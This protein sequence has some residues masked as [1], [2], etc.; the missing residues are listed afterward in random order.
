MR[1]CGKRPLP[2]PPLA[3][4]S[5]TLSRKRERV[6]FAPPFYTISPRARSAGSRIAAILSGIGHGAA[7]E[8]RR[9]G[10]EIIG[11]GGGHGGGGLRPDAAVDLDFDVASA[12]HLAHGADLV[13]RTGD[14]AL[15]AEAGID[16]HHQHEVDEVE[17]MRDRG[18]RRRRI[19]GDPGLLAER[20]DRLQRAVEMRPGLGVDGQA[21]GAGGGEIG[22]IG[23]DRRDHQMH[24]EGLGRDMP[25]RLHHLRTE[26]NIRHEMAVH[27]I[28]VD[29]VAASRHDV[30]DRFAEPREIAGE[31]GGEDFQ[32]AHGLLATVLER[33]TSMS[34]VESPAGRAR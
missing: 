10:D 13:E 2:H 7:F 27:D 19:E 28:D 31:N 30:A 33:Q 14:E 8:D 5:G 22:E 6:W 11:A 24:V 12:G 18:G 32:R 25:D 26:G 15:A 4:A 23:I 34:G 17:N 9:S 1:D 21:I 3:Y 20:P 29:D 16:A